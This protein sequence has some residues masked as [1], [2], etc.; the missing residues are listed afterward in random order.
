MSEPVESRQIR[1][2]VHPHL[3]LLHGCDAVQSVQSCI[4]AEKTRYVVQDLTIWD[5][6]G[7][8]DNILSDTSKHENLG[9]C[10]FDV[11]PPSTTLAQHQ[12]NTGPTSR[13]CWNPWPSPLTQPIITLWIS[14]SVHVTGIIF[15]KILLACNSSLKYLQYSTCYYERENMIV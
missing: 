4:T 12:A 11:G 13:V 7:K 1:R 9:Q 2:H 14:K 10:W 8:M 15:V 6:I 3:V 5:S